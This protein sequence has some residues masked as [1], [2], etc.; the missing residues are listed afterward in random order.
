M[1]NATINKQ[2]S[3]METQ[4]TFDITCWLGDKL[5]MTS[6]KQSALKWRTEI[7]GEYAK[8]IV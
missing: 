5:W 2:I 6:L 8:Q 3:E 7:T 4:S 1:K